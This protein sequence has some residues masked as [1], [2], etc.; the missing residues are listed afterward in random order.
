LKKIWTVIGLG[1]SFKKLGLDLDR[2][3]WQSAHIWL[4]EYVFI[5]K[6]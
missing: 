2:K 3:I 1:L 5:V 6:V 4:W